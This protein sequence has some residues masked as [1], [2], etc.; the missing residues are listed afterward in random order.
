MVRPQ[1][2]GTITLYIDNEGD[3]CFVTEKTPEA[4]E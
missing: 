4:A 2:Y 3:M 1:D